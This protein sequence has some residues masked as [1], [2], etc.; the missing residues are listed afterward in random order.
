LFK[1]GSGNKYFKSFQNGK[2]F[3]LYMFKK[4]GVYSHPVIAVQT[5]GLTIDN[6]SLINKSLILIGT[7]SYNRAIGGVNVVP[8]LKIAE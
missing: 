1:P 4:T 8:F 3:T 2:D 7:L 5:D 6:T